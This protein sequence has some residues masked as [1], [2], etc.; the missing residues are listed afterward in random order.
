MGW[1]KIL[2]DI[3]FTISSSPKVCR[4][5][6]KIHLLNGLRDENCCLLKKPTS[7]TDTNMSRLT[8]FEEKTL[9]KRL[10]W[11]AEASRNRIAM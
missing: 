11:I 5:D 10:L 3:Y 2:R 7:E 4:A 8:T 6:N 9:W 1:W